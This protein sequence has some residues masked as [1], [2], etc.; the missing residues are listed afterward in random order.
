MGASD[1]FDFLLV[2]VVGLLAVAWWVCLLLAA[3]RGHWAWLVTMIFVWFLAPLYYFQIVQDRKKDAREKAQRRRR[4]ELSRR[5]AGE[6]AELRRE[7]REL[8]ERLS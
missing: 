1:V 2:V 3:Q 7:I 8:K 4:M 6:A 5:R